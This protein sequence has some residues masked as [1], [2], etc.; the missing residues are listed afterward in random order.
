VWNI[1]EVL[2]VEGF[3]SFLWVL[4]MAAGVRGGFDPLAL[5]KRLG[6]CL[7]VVVGVVVNTVYF[8]FP[9]HVMGAYYRFLWPIYPAI[10]VLAALG[11][12]GLCAQS[13]GSGVAVTVAFALALCGWQ[14][15]EFQVERADQP[16][17]AAGLAGAHV[18]LGKVLGALV[19]QA[20]RTLTV[21]D[22][23][24]VPYYSRWRTV[25]TFGLND[26]RLALTYKEGDA[27]SYDVGYV[28]A[29][30]PDVMVLISEDEG[31]F[32]PILAQEQ[33]AHFSAAFMRVIS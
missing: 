11:V 1:G 27:R 20:T 4:L 31:L 23:G 32:L 25:D 9:A 30:R 18:R 17:Y 19:P 14:W 13:R 6:A 33:S 5:S 8:L 29:Q 12:C 22:A 7:P 10:V 15:V 24:A 16:E 3:T 21:S 26:R 2:P 28:M